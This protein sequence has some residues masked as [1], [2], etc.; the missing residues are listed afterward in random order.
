MA[1]R[2]IKDG[3]L[4]ECRRCGYIGNT[5][6]GYFKHI[7]TEGHV[8]WLNAAYHTQRITDI[9]WQGGNREKF[10]TFAMCMNRTEHLI[11]DVVGLIGEFIRNDGATHTPENSARELPLYRARRE[12]VARKRA[13]LLRNLEKK[14]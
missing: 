4:V 3:E 14:K 2:R 12:D 1:A 10:L 13:R 7:K 8:I 9:Q 5:R 6:I 11:P